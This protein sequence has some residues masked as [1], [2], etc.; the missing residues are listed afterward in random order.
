MS[1]SIRTREPAKALM[2]FSMVS[3]GRV[4]EL[5]R[6]FAPWSILVGRIALS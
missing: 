4:G 6:D 1:R 3:T 2:T 5:V